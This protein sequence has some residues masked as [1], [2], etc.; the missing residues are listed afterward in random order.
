VK[1]LVNLSARMLALLLLV[2]PLALYGAYLMFVAADRFVSE[3]V[4]SVRQSGGDGGGGGIPGAA[5]LLA[6]INPPAHEDTLYLKEFVLSRGLLATLE[7]K[8]GLREH[9]A[10][11]GADWPFRLSP[12]ASREDFIDYFRARVEV[13]FDD[14]AALLTVRT[15]GF[16]P[17]FAQK[18]NQ[19]ILEES[20]RFVNE[21][22]QRFARE[23]MRFAEGELAGAAERLQKAKNGLLAFQNRHRLIDPGQQ[24]QAAGALTVELQATRSRLEAELGGLLGF[25][26]EDSFQVKALRQRIAA[27]DRQIDAESRRATTNPRRGERLNQL[28]VEFQALQLQTQFAEDAY[29]LALG[30]VEN[31]RIDA[32]RK[33][34][35]LLVVEPP[36]LPETAEYPR[37]LYNLGTLLAICVLLF[38]IVRL[39]LATIREHQD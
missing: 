10:Q 30:A 33:I 2:L 24:A 12:E 36:S 8:L 39:V 20:E 4:I 6:G 16:E 11:A 37:Q 21:T 7:P 22:S 26:N 23:R 18:L 5:L 3:S 13:G 35:S 19:A 14:R 32:T 28:A 29:K 17:A 31:A 25:L 27:L 34:K 9:Y 1:T 38:A 15:Q